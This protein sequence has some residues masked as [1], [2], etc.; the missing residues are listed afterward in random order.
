MAE[1]VRR[2]LADG[3]LWLWQDDDETVSLAGVSPPAVGVAQRGTGVH[4]T[5]TTGPGLR[6]GRHRARHCGGRRSRRRQRRPL[7]TICPIPR[8]TPSTRRSA[9]SRITTPRN[10]DFRRRLRPRRPASP[11][12][13][14]DLNCSS[15]LRLAGGIEEARARDPGESGERG[16]KRAWPSGRARGRHRR[17]VAEE[18]LPGRQ[19]R[20]PARL[21]VLGRRRGV[22]RGRPLPAHGF[23]APPG[24]RRERPFDLPLAPRPFRPR[25]GGHPRPL[26][27]RRPGTQRRGRRGATSSWSCGRRTTRP[28]HHLRRLAEGLEQGLTLVLAKAVL[29][30]MELLGPEEGALAAVRE[31]A[32]FGLLNRE[33]VGAPG[34]RC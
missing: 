9:T 33:E 11:L 25:L 34:C 8:R 21:R 32:D 6:L 12:D 24:D 3:Q 26:R 14:L 5:G 30:L 18:G 20:L 28:R 19:G 31:G 16:A 7:T 17:G 13:P 4:A 27:R 22:R 1:L 23:P 15:A 10:R 2:R 29:G